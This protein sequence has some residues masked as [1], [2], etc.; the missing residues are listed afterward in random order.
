[1]E[2]QDTAVAVA[3]RRTYGYVPLKNINPVREVVAELARAWSPATP[4]RIEFSGQSRAGDPY[5]L[6]ANVGR[7][8]ALGMSCVTSVGH[9]VAEYVQ[10]FRAQKGRA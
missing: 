5:S 2:S 10:W 8:G 3:G 7:L 9:G 1:M 6:C 4:P